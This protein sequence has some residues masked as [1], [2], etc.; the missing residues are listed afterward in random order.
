MLVCGAGLVRVLK[1]FTVNP[2]ALTSAI[3]QWA[4]S[5]VAP[6]LLI[7][8][9]PARSHSVSL[10]TV[11]TPVV[12]LVPITLMMRRQCDRDECALICAH[13]EIRY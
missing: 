4:G 9:L 2:K 6:V 5:P 13:P 1:R 10:P 11:R 3:L 7:R 12:M 8:S